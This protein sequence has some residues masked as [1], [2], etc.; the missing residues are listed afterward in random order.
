MVGEPASKPPQKCGSVSF[1]P[2]GW[3]KGA[4]AASPIAPC[5]RSVRRNRQTAVEKHSLGFLFAT[6]FTGG[7]GGGGPAGIS[8]ERGGGGGS[9]GCAVARAGMGGGIMG[10]ATH[11]GAGGGGGGG[12]E[13]RGFFCF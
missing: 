6:K 5:P 2:C 7:R 3:G 12:G 9:P 10:G 13:D 8:S 11:H 1:P 4:L